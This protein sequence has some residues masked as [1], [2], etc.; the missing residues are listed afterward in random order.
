RQSAFGATAITCMAISA[1]GK[2][3]VTQPCRIALRNFKILNL[4]GRCADAAIVYDA[5]Y[6]ICCGNG[7]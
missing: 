3:V 2:G 1:R 4:G 7:A 6:A 5:I